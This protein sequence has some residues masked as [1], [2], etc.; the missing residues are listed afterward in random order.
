MKVKNS[1]NPRVYILAGSVLAVA[2]VSFFVLPAF[3]RS[4]GYVNKNLA[5]VLSASSTTASSFNATTTIAT[6]TPAVAHLKTPANV[7]SIYMTACAAS[8][9][10]FRQH[11]FSLI[12]GT[13]INAVVINIKDETGKVSLNTGNPMFAT[14]YKTSGC[15]VP[16][17][18][19][20]VQEFHKR[21]IY[22]IA[23]IAVF[24]DPNLVKLHPE[25]AVKRASDGG[26]WKDHKGI[27]WLEVKATPVWDYVAELARESYKQGFDEINF[28]YIRFPSDGN[29]NDIA[30]HYYSAKQETKAQAV[31]DFF[32]GMHDRLKDLGAPISVDLFGMTCTNTDDLGIGQVLENALPFFD[33]VAPMVY[34]SH[35]PNGWNGYKKPATMPYQV[36]KINMDAAVKRAIAASSSPSKIRP[37]IQDFNLGATYNA[38]MIEAELNGARAAGLNSYMVWDPKNIYTRA[39]YVKGV[40]VSTAKAQ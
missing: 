35:Y 18:K 14:A 4:A 40:A 1:Y 9:Q 21:G 23:R 38:T 33:Y 27:S 19:A 11:F 2:A 36:I 12:P 37:W 26:V 31:R 25:W 28:D 3:G 10:T 6:T 8:S 30:Y 15:P 17:M 24:Q 22:V 32:S 39:A 5:G 13:E 34:P 7:R 20:L 16:D 29:M